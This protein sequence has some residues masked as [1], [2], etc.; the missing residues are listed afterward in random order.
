MYDKRDDARDG[1]SPKAG[2]IYAVERTSGRVDDL[3]EDGTTQLL[4]WG[5]IIMIS[6]AVA[7]AL[8]MLELGGVGME[9]AHS[10]PGWLALIIG[11]MC[12]P[13]GSLLTLLGAAKWLRR[14]GLRKQLRESGIN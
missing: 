4:R 3:P 6:G 14:R 10:N 11:M 12:L 7:I 8:L 2:G 9:G 13:F 1:R 5:S